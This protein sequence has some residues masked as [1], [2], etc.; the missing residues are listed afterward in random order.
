MNTCLEYSNPLYRNNHETIAFWLLY[1]YPVVIKSSNYSG[2]NTALEL[3]YH[4]PLSVTTTMLIKNIPGL[5]SAVFISLIALFPLTTQADVLLN[6][7]YELKLSGDVRYR[8]EE[9]DRS[10]SVQTERTRSQL[11]ARIG[12]S[13]KP[14][15]IWTGSLRLSTDATATHSRD[16]TLSTTDNDKNGDFGLDQAYITYAPSPLFNLVLGKADLT[17]YQQHDVFWDRD[18]SPEAMAVISNMGGLSLSASQITLIEGNWDQDVTADT[19]Q[20]VYKSGGITFAYGKA[21]INRDEQ[22]SRDIDN[23]GSIDVYGFQSDEYT[24]ISAEERR[25]NW[26][27][28]IEYITSNAG[29]E[30]MARILSYQQKFGQAYGFRIYKYRVEAF[31]VMGDGRF[32]Q[33][34]FPVEGNTGIT[35]FEG[36][37]LQFD[38][39]TGKASSVDL[40]FYDM[41]RIHDPAS[42]GATA[43]DALMSREKQKRMQLNFNVSF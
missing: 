17:F 40:V 37:K 7:Q 13:F 28:G 42:L 33:D 12:A 36:Y 4:S 26:V 35:N 27:F 21:S 18:I 8:Y 30:D 15:K 20:M 25:G 31:S 23:N 32:S 14:S 34:N 5:Y 11:R 24:L 3:F 38:F 16:T 19:Y 1:H 6:K 10:N 29:S 2:Y 22:F 9:D 43:S 41:K 39:Y